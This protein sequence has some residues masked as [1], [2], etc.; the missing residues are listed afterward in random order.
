M[1]S[2][3]SGAEQTRWKVNEDWGL[4]CERVKGGDMIMNRRC[5][6]G[7]VGMRGP[8]KSSMAYVLGTEDDIF[9]VHLSNICVM[10]TNATKHGNIT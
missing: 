1:V 4:R 5:V 7:V 6:P 3:V 10:C 9:C 8:S 2:F